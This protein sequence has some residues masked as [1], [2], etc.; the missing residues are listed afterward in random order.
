MT[1]TVVTTLGRSVSNL[2]LAQYFKG[3]T[4]EW[5]PIRSDSSTDLSGRA[6]FEQLRVGSHEFF[7]EFEHSVVRRLEPKGE[8]GLSES[9]NQGSLKFGNISSALRG[10]SFT[11]ASFYRAQQ[12]LIDERSAVES[13]E[14][15]V[16]PDLEHGLRIM[17]PEVHSLTGHVSE[18][19]IVVPNAVVRLFLDMEFATHAQVEPLTL[20]EAGFA[21]RLTR[22]D[23]NG[24]YRFELLTMGSYFLTAERPTGGMQQVFKLEIPDQETFFEAK[25]HSY[26]VHGIV[27]GPQ[28]IPLRGVQIVAERIGSS[29]SGS[30]SPGEAVR[31]G[32]AHYLTGASEPVMTGLDGSYRITGLDG[33][34]PIFVTARESEHSTSRAGAIFLHENPEDNEVN[35]DMTQGCGAI[36]RLD[37]SR[38]LYSG[39]RL[40]AIP[41]RP[42]GP[43]VI[44]SLADHKNVMRLSQLAP[45]WYRFELRHPTVSQVVIPDPVEVELYTGEVFEMSFKVPK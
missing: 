43:E 29:K 36:A 13:V 4:N 21:N 6:R 37:A 34:Y 15:Q 32:D 11:R 27:T 14:V 42:E 16:G 10:S 33:S 9:L 30:A 22:T 5:N 25:L 38:T 44:S 17:I 40:V 3:D 7:L 8:P 12:K 19:G 35:L 1:V 26:E 28:G 39:F 20:N 45:G 31:S 41:L 18:D 23:S 24:M 2:R